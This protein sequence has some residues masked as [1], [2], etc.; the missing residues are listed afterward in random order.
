M[1]RH[2]WVPAAVA[3][4]FSTP[5]LAES[6]AQYWQTVTANVNLPA[7]LK[8]N[9]EVVVRSSD[10]KGLYEVEQNLMIGYKASKMVTL[11]LGYTHD[12]NYSHGDFTVMEHRFRQQVSFDGFARIGPVKLSGRVRLEERWREGATGTGW[13]LRPQVS[14]SLPLTGKLSLALSHESFIDLNTTSFQTVRGYERMRNAIS[15]KLP[16]SKNFAVDAGYLNQH[17]FV[18]GAPDK[19]DH[20]LTA[21]LS[22]AF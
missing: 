10:P 19:S 2:L 16:V 21:G 20:V 12:P 22:M 6:D 15:L 18:R 8:L 17:G 4:L 5:A 3:A 7:N 14:A 13:R 9:G 1:H 11:W